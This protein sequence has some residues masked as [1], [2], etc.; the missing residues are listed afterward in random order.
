MASPTQ[1]SPAPWLREGRDETAGPPIEKAPQLTSS[2]HR[3]ADGAAQ[4][5]AALFGGA[6]AGMFE[7]TGATTTFELLAEQAGHG[8]ALL[9]SSSL[10]ARLA[11]ILDTRAVDAIVATMF[12][13][14]PAVDALA[15]PTARPRTE[16]E[17]RLLGE[18]AKSLAEALRAAFAPVATFDLEFESLNTIEDSGLFG[19]KDM[20]AL[21]ARYAIKTP[22]GSFWMML[23]LPQSLTTPLAR[24]FARGPAAGGARLDP[25][26]TE[27]MESGVKRA[28]MTLIAIL[29]EFELTLG[30]IAGWRVGELLALTGEG[31]GR[32]RM[33]CGERG[34]FICELGERGDRYAL[35]VEDIIARP[36][37]PPYPEPNP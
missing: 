17:S 1:D 10:D 32:V 9:H 21:T 8:A 13:A 29:D 16:L 3:F 36:I 19:A 14:D 20:Q 23:A 34:V 27:R 12:G 24:L 7:A 28:R 5:L 18:V 31:E 6:F 22:G 25:K 30:E 26:W 11:M 37:E 4:A 2:L 35:E 15:T 33:E